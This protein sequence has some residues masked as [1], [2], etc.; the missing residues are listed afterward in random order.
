MG[1]LF[2]AWGAIPGDGIA[3]LWSLTEIGPINLW[4]KVL[5][6]H[7]PPALAVDVDAERFA[8]RLLGAYRFTE[9]AD[10]CSAAI[11]EQFTVGGRQAVDVLKEVFHSIIITVW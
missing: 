7:H 11:S 6:P 5:T 9:V 1:C 8:K 3:G 4:A 2:S 10:A